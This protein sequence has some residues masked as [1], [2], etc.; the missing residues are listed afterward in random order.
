MDFHS[1]AFLDASSPDVCRGQGITRNY[2]NYESSTKVKLCSL[3]PLISDLLRACITEEGLL[4][5]VVVLRAETS[6]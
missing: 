3:R 4:D 5:L 2:D 6:V 1:S